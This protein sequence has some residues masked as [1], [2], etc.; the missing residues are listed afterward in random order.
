MPEP[1]KPSR[2]SPAAVAGDPMQAY[3]D[4]PAAVRVAIEE[5]LRADL[6][7]AVRQ[8]IERELRG[9]LELEAAARVQKVLDVVVKHAPK[10]LYQ[11]L[12]ASCI[13]VKPDQDHKALVTEMREAASALGVSL[14]AENDG[15]F[16][17][18]TFLSG[19]FRAAINRHVLFAGTAVKNS[20]TAAALADATPKR[21]AG[22]DGLSQGERTARISEAVADRTPK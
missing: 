19:L 4:L 2:S 5:K 11:I 1:V 18:K 13:D 17:V 3:A 14:P 21:A 22:L 12:K 20:I 9:K 6:L 7:V 15:T 8:T 16:R 10:T